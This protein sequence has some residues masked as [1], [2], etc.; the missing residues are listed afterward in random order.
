[1]EPDVAIQV[2][3]LTKSYPPQ[4]RGAD[5]TLAVDDVSFSV[6]RG[7]VF[8]FLGPNGAGKTTTAQILTTLLPPSSGQARIMGYD[9][10]RDRLDAR[11]F[12]GVV[13]EVSNVYEEYSAWD[14]LV[15]SAKLYGLDGAARARQAELLLREF[16]LW[17]RRASR[18][19]E[20]SKGMK[21]RL[22]I[23][24]GLMHGPS[25][26]FLDEPTSGLDVQSTVG[27]RETIR[28]LKANGTTV[29][30]TTHNMDEAARVCDR[31]AI[32]HRGRI[33]AVDSPR[34]LSST[35][36]TLVS[37]EVT[38]EGDGDW[39]AGLSSLSGVDEVTHEDRRWRLRTATAGKVIA[40]VVEW[41]RAQGIA[42]AAVNTVEPSLEDVFVALT[43]GPAPVAGA[44]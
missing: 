22:C 14:N 27:I 24:M 6:G 23:A 36:S 32:I 31:V 25:V 19:A 3:H 21:R 30:L 34:N 38:F 5:A 40:A 29:F 2:E 17:D 41:S 28:R 26:V 4:R 7:E 20:F 12:M 43:A 11:R 16:A 18:A 42:I 13:P 39:S 9:V 44:K 37:V 10:V 33:A 35:V 15:F 8:G 1:M